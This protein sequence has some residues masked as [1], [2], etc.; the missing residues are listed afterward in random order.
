MTKQ[1]PQIVDCVH[2]GKPAVQPV[3][4]EGQVF[5]CNGCVKVYELMHEIEQCEIPEQQPVDSAK[6]AFMDFPEYRKKFLRIDEEGMAVAVFF[7]PDINCASCVQFL[8]HLHVKNDA[9]QQS[10]V[11]FPKKEVRVLF[12]PIVLAP[13]KLAELLASLGYPPEIREE[14]KDASEK[15][16][17]KLVTQIGVAGF[18]FGNIM[19]FS[20]PEY[21]GAEELEQNFKWS[22]A[23]L[24][25]LLSIPLLLF[26][27]RGYL[28]SAYTALKNR[29][30]NIDV[31]V[32][33]GIIA[34]FGRSTFEVL[35][36]TGTG[37]YDSLAGLIFFLLIGKWYQQRTYGALSY[38]R[39]YKSYFPIAVAK[40]EK[41]G[42]KFV[43]IAE[44]KPGDE[45]VI[46]HKEIIP[47]DGQ[48]VE[49]KASIDYSFVTG[50]ADPQKIEV[51]EPLQAGGRQMGASITVL[52]QSP[53]EQSKLTR[54]WNSEAFQ[55]E[56]DHSI[57]DPV[58]RLSKHFTWIILAI[59][60]G[61][62]AFWYG[63]DEA[64][65]WNAFT[66]TLIVACPCALALTL[67]F[68]FGST[69]RLMGKAGLYLKNAQV[70]ESMSKIK[71]LVFD[72]TGTLTRANDYRIQWKGEKLSSE[73]MSVI[74]SGCDQ[75]AHPL[76]RAIR[77]TYRENKVSL[78][79]FNEFEGKG[80]RFD[81]DGVSYQLGSARWL[82][83]DAKNV[84]GTV[85]HVKRNEEYLGYFS[86]DKPLRE[87]LDQELQQLHKEYDLHLISGDND[88]DKPRFQT[89]FN[90]GNMRFNQSPEDKLEYISSLQESGQVSM[91]GDGL[92]DA[93]ALKQ[94]D[95]GVAVV[96]DLYAFSPACDSILHAGALKNL[97]HFMRF[98]RKAMQTVR[99]SFVIS[100][101]YNAI[102]I[103]VAVQG[104][105][106]PLFAA[107]LMPASSVTVVLFTVLR[108][109]YQFRKLSLSE[110]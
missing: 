78:D 61:A 51:G 9:I 26:S 70:V 37:Y 87:G 6:Y 22:F 82:E 85:V 17:R 11:N 29:T 100:F 8:E 34:L 43:P 30:V 27:G 41:D 48:L 32:S 15:K 88:S 25:L 49:G 12:D 44:L 90:E 96:D 110:G 40:K 3:Y 103:G 99:W 73:G 39:D 21:L 57:A 72:K 62:F 28:T 81:K 31:P 102:G 19:L 92:N 52:V 79:D 2:C 91:V 38:D 101:I 89:Y 24:N 83:I 97:D 35:T 50:E 54:L 68:T 58:N 14:R 20:F 109:H 63:K 36:Q 93:G 1:A 65:A 33:I 45:I 108:T 76:S 105:L 84:E 66:A 56:Q 47:A 104:L 46:H 18:C 23:Y 98:S 10:E 55:K 69:M 95:M 4:K 67:P 94:A 106:T 77:R 13:S 75:S 74:A 59:S 86:F 42:E 71:H 107:V 7:L 5:C 80:I 64:I 16:S 53:V 60:I